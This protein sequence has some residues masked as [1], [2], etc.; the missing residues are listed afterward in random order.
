MYRGI[1]SQVAKVWATIGGSQIDEIPAGATVTGG[2]PASGYAHINAGA[3][4]KAGYTKTIWLKNY[5]EVVITPPPPPVVT[6]TPFTL[7]VD[8]YK[9]YSGEL[10]KA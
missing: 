3:S 5:A 2:A 8:G 4:W 6:K 9:P 1:T 10:E 7:S